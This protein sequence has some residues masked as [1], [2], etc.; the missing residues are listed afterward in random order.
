MVNK[1]VNINNLKDFNFE[2][3]AED[4]I[5]WLESQSRPTEALL[6]GQRYKTWKAAKCLFSNI[7]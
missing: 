3:D 7:K 4:T 5:M 2:E 6:L 1:D